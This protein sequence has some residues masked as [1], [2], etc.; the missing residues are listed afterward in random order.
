MTALDFLFSCQLKSQRMYDIWLQ[1]KVLWL[2]L[3]LLQNDLLKI[4]KFFLFLLL[5]DWK[6]FLRV[7]T[8]DIV[9]SLFSVLL[10]RSFQSGQQ[11][12]YLG[13]KI[14]NQGQCFNVLHSDID[15]RFTCKHYGSSLHYTVI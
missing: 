10:Q 5:F 8:I 13:S 2:N 12:K 1:I 15:K 3:K 6:E 9:F 7:S 4:G 14:K 11:V